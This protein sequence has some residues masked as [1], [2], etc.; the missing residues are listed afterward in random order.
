MNK[1][2]VIY[3]LVAGGVMLVALGWYAFSHREKSAGELIFERNAEEYESARF[4]QVVTADIDS[5]GLRDWEEQLWGTDAQ[6]PDT[7]GDGTTDAEEVR[8]GRDPLKS[9]PNDEVKKEPTSTEHASEQATETLTDSMTRL[10][11]EAYVVLGETGDLSEQSQA[12]LYEAFKGRVSAQREG[13]A[14]LWTERDILR[15]RTEAET[16]AYKT[17][18]TEIS[19][20]YKSY[21]G[22]PLVLAKEFVERKDSK[23][24]D[25]LMRLADGYAGLADDI[26]AVRTPERIVPTHTAML[27]TYRALS[28]SIR[29]MATADTDPLRALAGIVNYQKHI[30]TLADILTVLNEFLGTIKG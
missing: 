9:G 28:L 30:T 17:R 14:P 29:D 27:N 25:A 19:A 6:K 15:T 11:A 12:E 1:R 20:K 5:D 2:V 7:D 26:S 22:N 24:R 13:T 18:L 16:V 10:F 3:S 4:K 21:T 23:T 8:G